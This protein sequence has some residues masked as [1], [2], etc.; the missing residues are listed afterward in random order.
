L[1]AQA[2]VLQADDGQDD[3]EGRGRRD[4]SPAPPGRGA[5]DQL[6][7]LVEDGLGDLEI[8]GAL[9]AVE[10]VRLERR[11]LVLAELV[12]KVLLGRADADGLGVVHHGAPPVRW[13]RNWFLA[14]WSRTRR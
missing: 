8:F 2:Q 12:E 1:G 11:P 10:E 14:R 7:R 4:R 3:R 13:A 9:W 6:A 5:R